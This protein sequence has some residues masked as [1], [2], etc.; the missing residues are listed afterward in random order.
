MLSWSLAPNP[1]V[2]TGESALSGLRPL[3]SLL[4][5]LWQCWHQTLYS[6]KGGKGLCSCGW[7][8]ERP[9]LSE[10]ASEQAESREHLS[11]SAL[12]AQDAPRRELWAH[13]PCAWLGLCPAPEGAGPVTQEHCTPTPDLLDPNGVWGVGTLAA[14]EGSSG[15]P[16]LFRLSSPLCSLK[17]LF[18]SQSHLPK[19]PE[20]PH[21]DPH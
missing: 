7:R 3:P 20:T 10:V 6:R 13:W 12:S 19:S 1:S 16:W 17:S 2:C 14:L 21:P 8:G 5:S 9:G 11:A 4:S 18:S 15:A